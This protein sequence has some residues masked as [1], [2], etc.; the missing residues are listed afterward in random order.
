ME[1]GLNGRAR[2]M[3]LL[4]LVYLH[5]WELNGHRLVSSHWVE[6]ATSFTA[7]TDP[8]TAYQYQWWTYRSD[9]VGDWYL[10]RGNKGQFIGVFPSK[11]LVI[12]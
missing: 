8:S 6:E 2:D 12:A 9:A 5:A 11:D 3:A 1:S 7:E 10:A 4:G